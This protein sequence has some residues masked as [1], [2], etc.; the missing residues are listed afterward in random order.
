MY[1]YDLQKAFDCVNHEILLYK[2]DFYKTEGTFKILLKSYLTDRQQRVIFGH[3]SDSNNTYRWE[4]IKCGVSQG[5]ILGPLFFL[6]Y[7][8]DLPKIV[9]KHIS[10]VLYADD[11]SIILTDTYKLNF[12]KNLNQIFNDINAWF[13]NNLFT[14]N[15]KKKQYLEFLSMKCGNT[16]PQIIYNQKTISTG[17]ETKFLGFIIDD[18]LSWKQHIEQVFNRSSACYALHNIKYLVSFATVRLIYFAHVQSIISYGIILWG[19]SSHA[20]KVFILR[21]KIIRIITNT[22]PREF[23]RDIFKKLEIMTLYSQYIYSLLLCVINNGH[24]F[25]LV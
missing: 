5:P 11:T 7:I 6:F 8:N 12:E 2:L 22:K 16:I 15:L 18:T 25:S 4:T 9:N 20:K 3:I 10:M 21:K 13:N 17:T 14:L 24:V 23:C 1:F 19:G